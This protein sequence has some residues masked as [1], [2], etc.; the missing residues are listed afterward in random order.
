MSS[1]LPR[2][3]TVS[4]GNEELDMRL[5]GG[6]PHPSL[7]LMEGDNGT[8]KTALCT[9]FAKGY[10]MEGMRVVYVTTENTVRHFLE[11]A[12]NI[13]IDLTDYFL[14]GQLTVLSSNI[15]GA[16]WDR[17]RARAAAEALIKF[18]E[19]GVARYSAL[20]L[21]SMSQIL[22]YLGDGEIHTLLTSLRGVVRRG[23]TVIVTLHPGVVGE[24]VVR[25]FAAASDVYMRLALGEIGGRLVKVVNV[26]K[27]RGAPTLAET[28][29]AF[30]VDPAFGIKVVP[31][32]LAKV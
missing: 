31:L 23:T 5:G 8:G 11:Q 20:I 3:T 18:A 17:D 6:I 2:L 9:Q 14:K 13:S 26:V 4:T 28:S 27:I 30:D 21:D 1:Q 32:A 12:R 25:E 10:L 22:H 29:I 15:R 19:S 16:R 7:V 24:S